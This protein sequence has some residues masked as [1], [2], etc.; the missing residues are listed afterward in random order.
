M[1][2]ATSIPLERTVMVKEQKRQIEKAKE[3][4]EERKT[5]LIEKHKGNGSLIELILTVCLTHFSD[6]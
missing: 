4:D 6:T 2:R 1:C 5:D 3:K